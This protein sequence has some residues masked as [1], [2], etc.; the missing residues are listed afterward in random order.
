M[1]RNTNY[2][3]SIYGEITCYSYGSIRSINLGKL[4]RPH[5]SPKPGYIFFL[6]G[7]HP[8]MAQDF[9]LVKYYHLPRI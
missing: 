9:R 5:C 3:W 4:Y 8:Q 6:K 1:A 7:N 2:L